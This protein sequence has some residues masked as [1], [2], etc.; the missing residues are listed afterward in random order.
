MFLDFYFEKL[1]E[2]IHLDKNLLK[3]NKNEK[4]ILRKIEQI[5]NNKKFLSKKVKK[6]ILINTG[7]P[8]D[9]YNFLFFHLLV[10][11]N[12]YSDINLN[13]FYDNQN[14]IYHQNKIKFFLKYIIYDLFKFFYKKKI[15][16]FFHTIKQGEFFFPPSFSFIFFKRTE[17]AKK[18][19]DSIKSKEDLVNLKYKNVPIGDLVYDTYL[20]FRKKP[21]VNLNDNY[22]DYLIRKTICLFDEIENFLNKKKYYAI[23]SKQTSYI[24]NGI[25]QRVAIKKNIPFY[26]FSESLPINTLIKKNSIK[27]YSHHSDFLKFKKNFNL[28]KNK[29]KKLS[30]A[31]KLF[32]THLSGKI[33]SQLSYMKK[34]AYKN[35]RNQL[36]N[37]EII[38]FLHDFLDSPHV[39]GKLV[40]ADFYDWINET[41]N[42][43]KKNKLDKKVAIKPHPNS[44][45][46]SMIY[47]KNLKKK[48]PSF[49]W[50]NR[51]TSNKEIFKKNFKF[52]LS[53][54]GTVILESAYLNIPIISCGDNPAASF[55]F[56]FNA[57]N[58]K[59]YFD[60][61]KKA[62]TKKINYPANTKKEVLKAVYM[63]YLDHNLSENFA[64]EPFRF[65]QINFKKGNCFEYFKIIENINKNDKH[66]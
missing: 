16:K 17:K 5:N 30:D 6:N 3:I 44:V 48:Y 39:Y 54:Y 50:L 46:A 58:K 59:H 40:F 41:L 49:V 14:I 60:L 52:A 64:I 51:E 36:K 8:H 7:H 43:F 38:I 10:N 23:Y 26:C 18:I 31:K 56:N 35:N 22:L 24:Q 63:R 4:Y 15:V 57:K 27:D 66:P 1:S 25:L 19:I 55:N 21:T 62:L 37:F 33:V 28:L 12:K 61:I 45:Y 53:A 2:L 20:R 42:F 13:Y 29:K 65:K 32:E 11:S 47:E 9:F 34:T